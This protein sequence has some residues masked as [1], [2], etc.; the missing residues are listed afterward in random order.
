MPIHPKF[1]QD[2]SMPRRDVTNLLQK[3]L[4]FAKAKKAP[5]TVAETMARLA[6]TQSAKELAINSIPDR[7]LTQLA[8]NPTARAQLLADNP[9]AIANLRA[10]LKNPDIDE[11]KAN[12]IDE[13]LN[14]FRSDAR[15]EETAT[16]QTERRQV[17]NA[18]QQRGR[19]A[20]RT[21]RSAR[22]PS[23]RGGTNP[24]TQAKS[25]ITSDFDALRTEPIKYRKPAQY[26]TYGNSERFAVRMN[27]NSGM[28]ELFDRGVP[29]SKDQPRFIR[30][31]PPVKTNP[32]R[33]IQTPRGSTV[34]MARRGRTTVP[35]ARGSFVVA[36]TPERKSRYVGRQLDNRGY[37]PT[38]E[39]KNEIA[40]IDRHIDAMSSKGKITD[41]F[42][43]E[44]DRVDSIRYANSERE[45][46]QRTLIA[47][48]QVNPKTRRG[49]MRQR[50]PTIITS[51]E[52]QGFGGKP[53]T[54]IPYSE[55]TQRV[56]DAVAAANPKPATPTEV[57]PR[58]RGRPRTVNVA[59][60]E[61]PRTIVPTPS[62]PAPRASSRLFDATDIPADI[63]A[64]MENDPVLR[65]RAASRTSQSARTPGRNLPG[66]SRRT[67]LLPA[68]A[69]VSNIID[70]LQAGRSAATA[71]ERSA[72]AARSWENELVAPRTTTS[73]RTPGSRA[74]GFASPA[75]QKQIYGE[76]S[77]DPQIVDRMRPSQVDTDIV[78]VGER[79]YQGF[80][81]LDS[82][83]EFAPVLHPR[84]TTQPDSPLI[85]FGTKNNPFVTPKPA[86]SASRARTPVSVTDQKKLLGDLL[87]NP[88]GGQSTRQF[89]QSLSPSDRRLASML[90]IGDAWKPAT[91]SGKSRVT[92]YSGGSKPKIRTT[93]A[94]GVPA[95][96]PMPLYHSEPITIPKPVVIP[97]PK[98]AGAKVLTPSF[99]GKTSTP[100]VSTSSVAAATEDLSRY[101]PKKSEWYTMREV[102]DTLG[103]V[104]IPGVGVK[105]LVRAG[106]MIPHTIPGKA[107]RATASAYR[108]LPKWAKIGI[109]LGGAYVAIKNADKVASIFPR[110]TPTTSDSKLGKRATP[111]KKSMTRFSVAQNSGV[112]NISPK[113]TKQNNSRLQNKYQ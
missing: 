25:P 82:F 63:L 80:G 93:S 110:A 43:R 38:K 26:R 74:K 10:L 8:L 57:K 36:N 34:D 103:G 77:L 108:A 75:A 65:A 2:T 5:P 3:S 95:A 49:G 87:D 13:I 76:I 67:T 81:N 39:I 102:A 15:R 72:A 4:Y 83:D 66:A 1:F 41:D 44:A 60:T 71:P 12:A 45:K 22:T 99:G 97:E 58:G 100:S 105:A 48:E 85:G 91:R 109:A 61:T 50:V 46:L 31:L 79:P 96:M 27:R 28:P 78:Y 73:A 9:L 30:E 111:L 106:E 101:M 86:R 42:Y 17:L 59:P 98:P 20:E 21:S 11:V 24:A 16:R 90:N 52:Q 68:E 84:A 104:K 89:V 55:Q 6:S 56:S 54:A 112:K 33:F 69:K 64:E 32:K 19:D 40:Q 35:G 62:R 37:R 51:P 53:Y 29:G 23:S 14:G 107:V 88:V 47:R 7:Q 92:T 70:Q 113:Y 18:E 94:A